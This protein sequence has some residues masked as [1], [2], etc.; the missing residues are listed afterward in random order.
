MMN[1]NVI[2]EL[3]G[4]GAKSPTV[5][6]DT[7]ADP[8]VVIPTG[9]KVENLKGFYPPKRI[10]RSVELLE[11]GSFCDYVNRFK[12]P[13][14]L[15][16]AQVSEEGVEFTALLD[17]HHQAPQLS[18]GR[19][20]HR[21]T[22]TA[23][24]TPEWKVWL[25]SDRKAMAQVAFAE[26]LE[27]NSNLFV[28]PSGADLLELVRS[29]HGHKNAR[30]NQS[31]RLDNGA[32]CVSFD[33]DIEVNASIKNQ[34]DKLSLPPT[35]TAGI[36]IFQG[37]DKYS[38]TARLKTR[39]PDR[40]LFLVYETIQLQALVRANILDLVKQVAEKTTIIPLLGNA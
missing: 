9:Q 16:F 7:D 11:A 40:K 18:P 20:L 19:C 22:F 37:M 36:A 26:F 10:E 8:F 1:E 32:Q 30:F 15:I 13:E 21:A 2:R 27:E 34:T 24:Q 35:I 39:I 5:V 28:S 29:L 3:V 31:V 38:V 23:L 14:T 12:M 17:Y 25:A 33:E 6:H 4:L